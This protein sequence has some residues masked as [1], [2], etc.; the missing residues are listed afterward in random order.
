MVR[1]DG[2][3]SEVFEA[4]TF[5]DQVVERVSA[6]AALPPQSMMFT[7]ALVRDADALR[8]LHQ[9]CVVPAV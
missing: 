6:M 3:V 4:S 1:E 5:R 7:K 2:Q 8:K 9:V